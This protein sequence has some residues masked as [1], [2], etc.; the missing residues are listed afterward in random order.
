MFIL[1]PI[2][3][4]EANVGDWKVMKRPADY[5][6]RDTSRNLTCY[7]E[8]PQQRFAPESMMPIPTTAPIYNNSYKLEAPADPSGVDK[9]KWDWCINTHKMT[10]VRT[11]KYC[12]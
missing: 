6:C 5:D 11:Y 1:A 10:Y 8:R 3:S 2:C 9:W 4:V 12:L 7:V